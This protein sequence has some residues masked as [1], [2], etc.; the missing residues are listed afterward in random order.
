MPITNYVTKFESQLVKK[1]K[2]ELLTTD[3]TTQDEKIRFVGA[4]DV[5][6]SSLVMS[7]YKDHSRNGGFNRGSFTDPFQT[8]TLQHDR[9][10]EFFVDTMD[11]DETNQ[12]VSA[13]NLTN[14]FVEDQAIPETDVYRL[15][16]INAEFKALGGGV[17]TSVLTEAN[18]LAKIDD[19]NEALDEAQV[20]QS[21]R[22][23]Y[24]TPAIKT[25][26]KNATGITR[27]INVSPGGGSVNRNVTSLDE[28]KIMSIPSDRMKS[29]YNFADGFVPGET[30]V[31]QNLIL[32]HPKAVI[33]TIKHS[34]IRLWAPGTHTSGD[35]YL[36]Q[37]R[38]YQDLFVIANRV[39]GIAINEDAPPPPPTQG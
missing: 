25:L 13:A 38:S 39:E 27:Q 23:L 17:D 3:L 32:L 8:L 18:I 33:A 28:L 15:S 10:I 37:N 1:F 16:K 34:Y 14:D 7:G 36:Y 24:I 19:Y 20:P 6:I 31:Q 4:R 22:I 12:E 26:L 35:G 2:R 9:D 29:V 5:R 21:G 30:A 11:V